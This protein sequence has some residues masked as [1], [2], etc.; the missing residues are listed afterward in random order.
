MK[1][2]RNKA[3][4]L[5]SGV[6]LLALLLILPVRHFFL[7]VDA[8][9]ETYQI[10]M[11][12]I[13]ENGSSELATLKQGISNFT[14]DTMSMKRFVALRDELDGKYDALYIGKGIYS[15]LFP[16][17]QVSQTAD[18]RSKAMITNSMNNDITK[19][20]ADQITAEFINKGL[21]VIFNE[22]AFKKNEAL[23]D[24]NQQSRLYKT[25]KAERQA[26]TKA[27]V[28]FLS[29]SQLQTF[30]NGLK[31]SN[32]ADLARLK[33]RPRLQITNRSDISDYD[34]SVTG[35]KIYKAGEQLSFN[36]SIAN[37]PSLQNS[38]LTVKLYINL[39]KSLGMSDRDLVAE[40]ETNSSTGTITYTLPR[41]FSGP[42]YW[43]LELADYH[44]T[45]Q[46]KDF[47]SGVIRY[48]GEKTVVKILQIMPS[49]NA[50][51]ANNGTDTKSSLKTDSNMRQ[52]YL[53]SDDYQLQIST[54]SVAD[55]N[56]YVNSSYTSSGEYGLNGTYDMLI[57]GFRDE[58]H[59]YAYLN[60]NAIKAVKQ[61]I[62][63]YN[64]S[65]LFTHDTVINLSDSNK[66]WVTN[67]KD[68]TGQI[69]PVNNFGSNA[70]NPST[71]VKP[72]ND[73]LLMNYPFYLSKS[74]GSGGQDNANG[75]T[76]KVA[77][78]HNQYFTL[79]LEDPSVVSWYNI[80]SEPGKDQRDTDDSWNHYYTYSKGNVTYSGTGHV[81]TTSNA[82]FPD[83]EQKLFVNTMYRAFIGA[84]HA[85]E[86][87]VNS[88]GADSTLYSYQNSFLLDYKVT[89][90][91]F[92]DRDLTTQVRF[93]QGDTYL[94]NAGMDLT[95]IK[96]GRNIY[97]SFPNPLPQGGDLIIEI[98]AWDSKGALATKLIPI[99][100]IEKNVNLAISR[101]L[102]GNIL[103]GTVAKNDNVMI[104][105]TIKPQ[106]VA[107]DKI[108]T[109]DQ[110]FNK[111]IISDIIFTEKLPPKL[112][113]AESLPPGMTRSGNASEGYTLSLRL[114]N[115]SYTLVN[116][117]GSKV[118]K[119]S[120]DQ[121]IQFSIAVT[122][123]A[124]GVYHL[125]D[126][127]LSYIDI[128][129]DPASAT[130]T[131]TPTPVTITTASALGIA[132]E[133]GAFVLGETT[134]TGGDIWRNVASGGKLSVSNMSINN[135]Y[136]TSVPYAVVGGDVLVFPQGTIHGNVLYSG[137]YEKKDQGTVTGSYTKG[138]LIDF[139][140]E[141][142]NLK[143]F[144][145]SLGNLTANGTSRVEYSSLLVD[146]NN[147]TTNIIDVQASDF[148]RVTELKITAPGNSVVILNIRGD[149][150]S[151][152]GGYQLLGGVSGDKVLLNFPDATKVKLVTMHIL[153]SIL[154]PRAEVNLDG[155]QLHG[156][157]IA[158]IF[159]SK[160]TLGYTPFSGSLPV[161]M[162]TPTPVPTVPP[163]VL[164]P[165]ELS[166]G[167]LSFT[168]ETKLKSLYLAPKT[169]Y[170]GDAPSRLIPEITPADM[171]NTPVQWS[172]DSSR[173]AS[174][175][176]AT[177]DVTAISK[178]TAQVTVA[179]LDGSG[180]SSTAT[181]TVKE[182][183]LR[184]LTINGNNSTNI[185]Q[186]LLLAGIYVQ[187]NH[188]D[189]TPEQNIQY[190]W[191]VTPLSENE[192]VKLVN[193]PGSPDDASKQQFTAS[194]PGK[195]IVTLTVTSNNTVPISAEKEITVINPL[196]GLTISGNPTIMIGESTGLSATLAPLSADA[197][198]LVWSFV[199]AA[200][201]SYGTLSPA[202]DG[203]S[204]TFKAGSTAKDVQVQVASGGITSPPFTIHIVELTGL[205]FNAT[206]IEITVGESRS[207]LPSL[208][209]TPAAFTL[210]QIKGNLDWSS[211][212]TTAVSVDNESADINQ[213]GT[214][215]GLKKGTSDI[216]VTYRNPLLPD[217]PPV[218][219]TIR[220][221]VVDKPNTD[222][223]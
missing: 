208:W 191:S 129:A 62:E 74:N 50:G 56:S 37:A 11:L 179:A 20:K 10:R 185:D 188:E 200:D 222:R 81:F 214:V 40:R 147:T 217:K 186:P 51:A 61:F 77:N 135:N 15:P 118:F 184:S 193:D 71:L 66:Q 203:R 148:S 120:S 139:V 134:V 158:N 119:P 207:L 156:N 174:L 180:L 90:L 75:G 101:S 164:M 52:S 172:I 86:I 19:L 114:A 45:A 219:G 83:W 194:R 111:Q 204:A 60:D 116:Q 58:Y 136:G 68:I 151:L 49:T 143:Q 163:I 29:D 24:S 159:T 27:N 133:F 46:L 198:T 124:T 88:P 155:G 173:H 34:P 16:G 70:A 192:T 168:A 30:F 110:A 149:S 22:D 166:F 80:K 153:G 181:I 210:D 31:S 177:G 64:Q 107:F 123:T 102:S 44:N 54:Q 73:G 96:S 98:K 223:Y 7:N 117:A 25:F 145:S 113:L 72:V 103:N 13:T 121:P 182:R 195:Y 21:Y 67:F 18:Q 137:S 130:V 104:D 140:T 57:F 146:G 202:A 6:I 43:K 76:P 122:P 108:S 5:F 89:D 178:G 3:L 206:E 150:A 69:D 205:R 165:T 92:N 213:R 201:A 39:D 9:G 218:K 99:K 17:N 221:K 63:V 12:E 216:T 85:P 125:N 23:S 53:Q 55:F 78:T 48:S 197:G 79:N 176:T 109:A 138:S 189:A 91:D 199:N 127:K 2:A 8:T 87:T 14:V 42:L 157:L 100:I 112:E 93:M 154:A 126:S 161:L 84:N 65:V 196:T 28:K 47:S 36:F 215:T 167:E 152:Q 183:S 190:Q 35:G 211:A 141:G 33:Q 142:A 97:Q 1:P 175:D 59:K 171:S 132:G 160:S 41:T 144:S 131:P 26:K 187:E 169:I 220:V 209:P 95:A 38:P 106:S 32:S 105:Y 128:H 115:V 4:Y 82:T 162:P 170:I 94:N 212:D